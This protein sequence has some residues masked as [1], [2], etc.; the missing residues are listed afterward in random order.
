MQS[1]DED[2]DP[3]TLR[4]LRVVFMYIGRGGVL[5]RFAEL[6]AHSA[7]LIDGLDASFVVSRMN[8]HARQ[9]LSHERLWRCRHSKAHRRLPQRE[10]FCVRASRLWS[11]WPAADP[12]LS[13]I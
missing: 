8:A 11:T 1:A 7:K 10:T 9:S 12:M 3:A 4:G 5:A 13:S 6:L 2:F